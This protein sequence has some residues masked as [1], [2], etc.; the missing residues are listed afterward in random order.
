MAK[1]IAQ[2]FIS[3]NPRGQIF[4]MRNYDGSDRLGPAW[5]V[6]LK[7]IT[8]VS[9]LQLV[10]DPKGH[11]FW[12]GGSD[13]SYGTSKVVLYELPQSPLTAVAS[14]S[15]ADISIIPEDGTSHIGNSFIPA[16]FQSAD[17]LFTKRTLNSVYKAPNSQILTDLSWAANEALWDQYFFSGINWGNSSLAFDSSSKQIVKDQDEAIDQLI[18]NDPRT[19]SPLLNPRFKYSAKGSNLSTVKNEVKDYSKIASYLI[20]EGGFNVN[21]TSKEAWMAVL[22]ALNKLGVDYLD[23]SGSIK[24]DSNT[25]IPFTRF[26]LPAGTKDDTANNL[27]KWSGYRVLSDEEISQ[28]AE[29][30]VDQVK[31]R[32]PFMGLSDF[33]NRRLKPIPSQPADVDKL[34]ALQMAIEQSGINDALRNG[35]STPNIE[36]TGVNTG[37]STKA[38]SSMTGA[39]GYLM[40]SDVLNSIGSLLRTRSD[41]FTVRA[42]GESRDSKGNIVATAWCEATIQRTPEWV[43]PS[44]EPYKIKD[45]SYPDLSSDTIVNK[46]IQNPSLDTNNK[47]NGRRMNIVSFKWLSQNEI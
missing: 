34:G 43:T 8:D 42:Y 4:D 37:Q 38:I 11:G 10:A 1:K 20:C 3:F 35:I 21:S 9:D 5:K 15:H 25:N 41:T 6:E 39:P 17:K 19:A 33:I 45:S 16:A 7:S 32:G 29:S 28:L 40:Q 44:T 23:S 2:C 14:L 18:D 24:T 22:G 46:W 30:I 13:A 31:I 47:N 12:G 36:T 27:G 26:Q